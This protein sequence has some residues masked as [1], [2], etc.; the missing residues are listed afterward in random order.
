MVALVG[1]KVTLASLVNV[2]TLVS[3]TAPVQGK[4]GCAVKVSSTEPLL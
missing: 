3:V 4:T 2:I 1:F